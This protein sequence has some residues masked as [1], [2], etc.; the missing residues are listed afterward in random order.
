MET[1]LRYPVKLSGYSVAAHTGDS[2]IYEEGTQEREKCPYLHGDDVNVA[3]R[4]AHLHDGSAD[5]YFAKVSNENGTKLPCELSV[6]IRG[7][8]SKPLRKNLRDD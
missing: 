4:I 7:V 2:S 6:G 5:A 1:P 3:Q 8:A